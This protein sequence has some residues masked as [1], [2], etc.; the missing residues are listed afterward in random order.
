MED[1]VIAAAARVQP[2]KIV[3]TDVFAAAIRCHRVLWPDEPAPKSARALAR[4]LKDCEDRLDAWRESAARA[5]ADEALNFVMS[6]Y[7]DINL[8]VLGALRIGAKYS[9]DPELVL[10]RQE[11]AYSFI[12]YADIHNWT[13]NPFAQP[14]AEED[15][16]TA[17]EADTAVIEP[18]DG[19]EQ[20]SAMDV[21]DEFLN[22]SDYDS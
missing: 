9:E 17:A 20:M 4:N 16:G 1:Q 21:I 11:R 19:E 18:A 8:D 13:P 5:G 14:E 15:A 3:G 22:A 12:Q 10:K 7:E 2:L 6:W